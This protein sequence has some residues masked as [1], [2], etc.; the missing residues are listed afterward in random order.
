MDP[1]KRPT[2]RM[3]RVRASD[4]EHVVKI[5][6]TPQNPPRG[7]VKEEVILDERDPRRERG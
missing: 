5:Q 2:T 4:E 3:K 7:S 6:P 1:S